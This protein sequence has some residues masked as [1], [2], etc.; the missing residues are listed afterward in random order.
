MITDKEKL[1]LIFRV[2]G[3]A[4]SRCYFKETISEIYF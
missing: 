1:F 4:T 3:A 2:L